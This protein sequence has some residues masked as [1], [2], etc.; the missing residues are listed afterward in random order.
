MTGKVGYVG[1]IVDAPA[2]GKARGL[3]DNTQVVNSVGIIDGFL[4]KHAFPTEAISQDKATAEEWYGSFLE[5]MV[6]QGTT[7]AV[8]HAT[9]STVGCNVLVDLAIRRSGPRCYVGKV[10]MDAFHRQP[11]DTTKSLEEAK[12]FIRRTI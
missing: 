6:K 1:T 3:A 10:N 12:L 7:T 5:E 11:E 2:F 9:S 8:F 4:A